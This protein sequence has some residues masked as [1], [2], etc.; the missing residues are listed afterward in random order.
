MPSWLANIGVPFIQLYAA[1][2][3]D[4][5]LYTYESLEILKTGNAHIHHEKATKE[6]GFSPRKLE[7]TISDTFDWYRENGY[8]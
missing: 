8:L 3:H 5:P 1:L 7:E 6:F 4:P 2:M